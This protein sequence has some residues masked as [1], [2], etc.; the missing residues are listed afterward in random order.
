MSAARDDAVRAPARRVGRPTSYSADLSEH[1]CLRIASGRSL[2]SVCDDDDMPDHASVY[3]W[4]VSHPEFCDAIARARDE[5]VEAYSD[6]LRDLG[7]QALSG[8]A[9]PAAV[10]VAVDAYDRAARLTMPR[11]QRL[12]VAYSGRVEVQHTVVDDAR[13]VAFLLARAQAVDAVQIEGSIPAAA[14]DSES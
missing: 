9:D 14:A 1:I 8:E 6:H 7:A 2:R 11:T 4:I 10:R 12:D 5:R 3:R 13:A